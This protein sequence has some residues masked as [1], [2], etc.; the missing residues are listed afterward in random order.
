M[1]RVKHTVHATG[2]P[3]NP[4]GLYSVTLPAPPWGALDI[5]DRRETAPQTAPIRGALSW[6]H[7]PVLRH[8]DTRKDRG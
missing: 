2:S 8:A 7:D 1:T 4:C 5:S 3:S 6:T